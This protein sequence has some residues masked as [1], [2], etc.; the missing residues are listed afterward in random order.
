MKREAKVVAVEEQA[1]SRESARQGGADR[2]PF[3]K[4]F[5]QPQNGKSGSVQFT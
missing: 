3:S 5:S 1:R 2:S 4:S